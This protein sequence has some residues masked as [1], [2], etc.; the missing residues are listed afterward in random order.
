MKFPVSDMN[1]YERWKYLFLFKMSK[2]AIFITNFLNAT[3]HKKT[4]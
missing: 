1:I 3:K 4:D 2:N